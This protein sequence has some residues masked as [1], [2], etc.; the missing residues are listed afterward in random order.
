[1]NIVIQVVDL[2]WNVPPSPNLPSVVDHDGRRYWLAWTDNSCRR[3]N[4]VYRRRRVGYVNLSW[5]DQ[6]ILRLAALFVEPK[7]QG[8][9]LAR[10]VMCHIL[11]LAL[12]RGITAIAGHLSPLD[13]AETPD[14]RG[15]YAAFGFQFSD[16]RMRLDLTNDTEP[17]E[18]PCRK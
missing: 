14:L 9:G 18:I 17:W 4:I 6:P 3:L 10:V 7:H 5:E 12:R 15:F 16:A 8:R 11:Q 2:F 13:M 1:M